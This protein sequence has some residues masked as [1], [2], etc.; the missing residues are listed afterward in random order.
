MF[1]QITRW[2]RHVPVDTPR[3]EELFSQ[4]KRDWSKTKVR[5]MQRLNIVEGVHAG[6]QLVVIQFSSREDWKA[7]HDATG[8][9]LARINA[10]IETTG[11]KREE[12][13]L[14]EQAE[15]LFF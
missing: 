6:K 4:M 5:N 13:I 12:V 3:A 8:A 14:A 15:G 1:Y 11:C 10:E 2:S 7:W 9:E